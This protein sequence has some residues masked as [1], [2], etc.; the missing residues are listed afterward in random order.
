MCEMAETPL[1]MA[2]ETETIELKTVSTFDPTGI[3]AA[4]AKYEKLEALHAKLSNFQIKFT[5]SGLTEL[6]REL[7][8]MDATLGRVVAKK[9]FD[10]LTQQL[11]DHLARV[12]QAKGEY[13]QARTTFESTNY[14]KG[15]TPDEGSQAQRRAR[16]DLEKR[17]ADIAAQEADADRMLKERKKLTPAAFPPEAPAAQAS[18]TPVAKMEEKIAA[19]GENGGGGAEDGGGRGPTES[20]GGGDDRADGKAGR[21]DA[22]EGQ[23]HEGGGSGRK[24]TFRQGE[25]VEGRR[26]RGCRGG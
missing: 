9:G 14:F 22:Q 11:N 2:L 21:G 12:R 3:D 19:K 16:L 6:N 1:P 26:R 7:N 10:Q 24:A 5:P 20:R 18:V 8:Q 15:R 25:G 4:I 13:E 17:Q 23:E